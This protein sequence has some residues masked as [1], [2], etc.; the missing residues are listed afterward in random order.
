MLPDKLSEFFDKSSETLK[1]LDFLQLSKKFGSVFS[2]DI[3]QEDRKKLSEII[4]R[5]TKFLAENY[6]MDYSLLLGIE[7]IG[8]KNR[9]DAGRISSLAGELSEMD[10]EDS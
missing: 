4:E 3:S 6:L 1:D 7:L 2:I 8:L 5:D 10:K 9:D